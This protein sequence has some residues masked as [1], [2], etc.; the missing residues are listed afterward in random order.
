MRYWFLQGVVMNYCRTANIKCKFNSCPGHFRLLTPFLTIPK[1]NLFYVCASKPSGTA[2]INVYSGVNSFLVI[3]NSSLMYSKAWRKAC[4]GQ[5]PESSRNAAAVQH[6]YP[7]RVNMR[8]TCQV[9]SLL[10]QQV[11]Q[12][13]ALAQV[14]AHSEMCVCVCVCVCVCQATAK[15]LTATAPT[16]TDQNAALWR[17]CT[18]E[19]SSKS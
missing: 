16:D 8:W 9:I 13:G 19:H 10:K 1:Y 7:D 18:L 12:S 11:N 6:V 2:A 14:Q 15:D 4:A 3:S 5:N 17:S